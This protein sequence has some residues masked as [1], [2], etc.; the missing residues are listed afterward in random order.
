[1]LI[2]CILNNGLCRGYDNVTKFTLPILCMFFFSCKKLVTIDQPISSITTNATFSTDATATSAVMGIYSSLTNTGPTFS[3][4][5]TTLYLGAASDELTKG[6]GT[7]VVL[8]FF[9]NEVLSNNSI[10]YDQF[11]NT[12]YTAIFQANSCLEGLQNT[13]S[14]SPAVKNQL[15]GECKFLRAFVYFYFANIWGDIPMPLTADWN[16]T[17]LLPRTTKSKVYD[18]I[19][20][21]LKDAQNLLASDYSFAGNE[22]VRANK[23][24]ATALL[25][26]V[27]L[28]NQ[29]WA[30]AEAQAT[31][32]I[33][34]GSYMLNSDLNHVFLKNSSEAI[35]QFQ[36]SRTQQPFGVME[37]YLMTADPI[38]YLTTDFVN[39][40][41]NLDKRK[42]AWTNTTQLSNTTVFYPFKYKVSNGASGGNIPEYYMVLRLAEQYIIRAEA[43]ARLNKIAEAKSNLDTIRIRA[44]LAVTSANDQPSLLLAIEKERR[45]EFFAEWAHRWFDLVRTDRANTVLGAIKVN[46]WQ[47]TDQLFPIP[48]SE[49]R[50]NPNLTQNPGYN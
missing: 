3:N 8:P 44:G 13:A 35:L 22:K 12:G 40:F 48:I 10:L 37:Q 6:G 32:V 5:A 36:P 25:S 27:Y 2:K 24:A 4:G 14:L 41:E 11:W 43:N 29:Q 34:S 49:I 17:Y 20:A 28:Y 19:I 42:S 21:D 9:T 7:G 45:I 39:A 38:F 33:N 1:M 15:I 18:Q 26:R 16:K 23:L 46:T 30:D 50:R 47:T 31:V